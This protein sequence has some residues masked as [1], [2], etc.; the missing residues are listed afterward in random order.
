[1]INSNLDVVKSKKI[2]YDYAELAN[3]GIQNNKI[4]LNLINRKK[5]EI[6]RNKNILYKYSQSNESSIQ[7]VK[8]IILELQN[9]N[10]F[11]NNNNLKMIKDIQILKEKVK[12]RF[13]YILNYRD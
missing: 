7:M 10:K 13:F 6:S 2:I 1:M 11:V 3:I 8:S 9:E 4:L 12:I 5:G